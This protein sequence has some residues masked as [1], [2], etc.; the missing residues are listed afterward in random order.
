MVW[1]VDK[2]PT[3]MSSF[4]EASVHVSLEGGGTKAID[5]VRRGDKLKST[6]GAAGTVAA[7]GVFTA[8]CTDVYKFSAGEVTMAAGARQV[9]RLPGEDWK[10]VRDCVNKV[11]AM[12]VFD[13]TGYFLLFEDP[14]AHYS[15]F[16]G[17]VEVLATPYGFAHGLRA[18][19]SGVPELLLNNRKAAEDKAKAKKPAPARPAKP[20]P[21]GTV[22]IAEAF[23]RRTGIK[24][25]RADDSDS[26]DDEAPAEL[27]VVTLS[28][29]DRPKFVSPLP[30]VGLPAGLPEG[31]ASDFSVMLALKD[32]AEI[33]RKMRRLLAEVGDDY[34]LVYAGGGT[35]RITV[36]NWILSYFP[37]EYAERAGDIHRAVLREIASPLRTSDMVVRARNAHIYYVDDLRNGSFW[38]YPLATLLAIGPG[39]GSYWFIT[40]CQRYCP[41][42]SI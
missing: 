21:A 4:S 28:K 5:E 3:G 23:A 32:P 30:T 37:E 24:R 33:K 8:L 40:F 38:N 34:S 41:A 13:V 16:V 22:G 11:V 14:A 26:D 35:A 6:G 42:R 15:F 25:V 17:D 36:P 9:V 10:M 39:L 19:K 7:V 31:L 20:R 27:P 18:V 1:I 12:K 2:K 29:L